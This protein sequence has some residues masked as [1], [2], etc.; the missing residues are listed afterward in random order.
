MLKTKLYLS[1]QEISKTGAIDLSQADSF[2]YDSLDA[3]GFGGF[4]AMDTALTGPARHGGLIGR[5]FLQHQIAGVVRTATRVRVLDEITGVLTAGN[6]HD[7]EVVL[8]IATPTGR[9]ELYGDHTNIP[10]ANYIPEQ[11]RRSVVRFEQG[12]QVNKLE[13]ARQGAAGYDVAVEKRNAASESLEQSRER[14]G[15][16]GFNAPDTR[17]FGLL[18]DPNLPAYE[19]GANWATGGYKEIIGD[20]TA[21]F[22]RLESQSGG[23]VRD[24][25]VMKLVLPMGY[26]SYMNKS[27]EQ[28]RGETVWEW[29]K[30]NYPSVTISFSP[31]FV[32]ANGGQNI[33]YL[34]A[35][36]VDGQGELSATI[37]Q[38]VPVKYQVLGSEA[39]IKGYIEDATNATAGVIVARP[40]AVTRLTGI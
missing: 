7:E 6:W 21:M 39:Q 23:N 1:G 33:A 9:A 17:V 2:T 22:Q 5:E 32:K 16:Y 28:G 20:I 12:F 14:V 26:R 25:S 8:N 15:Y 31:E 29:L 3:L 40:W 30:A 34:F 24:D 37:L 19:T 36:N 11:E 35:D 10:L 38:V 18:N 27:N 13:E 4:D